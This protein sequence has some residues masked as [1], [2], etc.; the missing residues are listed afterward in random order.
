LAALRQRVGQP[1]TELKPP[2]ALTDE[3]QDRIR[4]GL[5]K[6]PPEWAE[7][8]AGLIGVTPPEPGGPS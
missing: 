7:H 1:P 6:L 8:I 2:S 3:Q 5:A 4:A